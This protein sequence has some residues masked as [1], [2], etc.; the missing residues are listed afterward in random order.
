MVTKRKNYLWEVLPVASVWI[1]A[2]DLITKQSWIPRLLHQL[3]FPLS[4]KWRAKQS[5]M[6]RESITL[7]FKWSTVLCYTWLIVGHFLFHFFSF[8]IKT[9][10]SHFIHKTRGKSHPSQNRVHFSTTA[11]IALVIVTI[12]PSRSHNL[13]A[14]DRLAS[15]LSEQSVAMGGSL[16][17]ALEDTPSPKVGA[18]S[19]ALSTEHGLLPPSESWSTNFFTWPV[20]K[21]HVKLF[22]EPT[23]YMAPVATD[24]KK[25]LVLLYFLYS[26]S[27]FF[28]HAL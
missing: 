25:P 15:F 5:F 3:R 11:Y 27:H 9:Q 13:L 26:T 16:L 18:A 23:F 24:L 7:P 19:S 10:G 2:E 12:S 20:G 22:K 28:L 4:S 14:M 1:E 8:F 6:Y 17:D 21:S